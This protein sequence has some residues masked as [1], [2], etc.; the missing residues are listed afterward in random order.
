MDVMTHKR[1]RAA[2]QAVTPTR[3]SIAILTFAGDVTRW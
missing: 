2:Y 1:T 3:A